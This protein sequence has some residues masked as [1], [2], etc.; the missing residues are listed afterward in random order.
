MEAAADAITEYDQ[1]E[2][3]DETDETGQD[4][5]QH[6]DFILRVGKVE[7]K[8][9]VASGKDGY[10][11]CPRFRHQHLHMLDMFRARMKPI[12]ELLTALHCKEGDF[13]IRFAGVFTYDHSSGHTAMAPDALD[14]KNLNKNPGGKKG[15]E[16][17]DTRY[18]D[19]KGI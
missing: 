12:E 5:A 4:T 18:T 2:H 9:K 10:W 13:P 16:M 19:H 3:N 1:A 14:A 6:A 11:N 17:R 8:K 7:A 15:T